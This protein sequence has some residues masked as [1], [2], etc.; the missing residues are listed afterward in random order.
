MRLTSELTVGVDLGSSAAHCVCLAAAIDLPTA[1]SI[2]HEERGSQK[3]PDTGNWHDVDENKL[4]L[5]NKWAFGGEH[6]I[7]C[8]P[9]GI[10]NTVSSYSKSIIESFL[11]RYF[12]SL[13]FDL[14]HEQCHKLVCYCPRICSEVYAR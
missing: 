12:Y 2:I 11:Y 10:D 9:S 6:I 4:D 14:V 5:I 3:F 7:D 1:G 8:C 13:S